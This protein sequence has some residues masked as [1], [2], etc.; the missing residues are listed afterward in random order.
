MHLLLLRF[1]ETYSLTIGDSLFK[2]SND[3]IIFF[4]LLEMIVTHSLQISQITFQTFLYE[5]IIHGHYLWSSQP[6]KR[7]NSCII[8]WRFL[9]NYSLPEY[10][11]RKVSCS[12][13]PGL[14]IKSYL[15]PIIAFTHWVNLFYCTHWSFCN[16]KGHDLTQ[17]CSGKSSNRKSYL[18]DRRIFVQ[19]SIIQF[20][21]LAVFFYKISGFQT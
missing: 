13:R 9:S 12:L 18:W 7:F 1:C 11:S 17:I 5:I 2:I 15:S 21:N 8:F 16:Q 14:D 10:K 3:G 4:T 20:V 6:I 19:N